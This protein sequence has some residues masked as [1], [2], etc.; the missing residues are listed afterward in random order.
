MSDMTTADETGGVL[1]GVTLAIDTDDDAYVLPSG[2]ERNLVALAARDDNG[3]LLHPEIWREMVGRF[4]AYHALTERAEA[5]EA[6]R[7]EATAGMFEWVKKAEKDAGALAAM[8]KERDDCQEKRMAAE[9]D[10]AR[11]REALKPFATVLKDNWFHQRDGLKIRCGT[12][13]FDL[14]LDLTLGDFRKARAALK[15]HQP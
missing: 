3:D 4:N 7:D 6:E 14:R 9:A 13:E 15:G 5:A 1:E 2:R 8:R 10:A 12:N 11:L